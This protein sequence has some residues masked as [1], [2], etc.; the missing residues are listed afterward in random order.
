MGGRGSTGHWLRLVRSVRGG[1]LIVLRERAWVA[2]E[3]RRRRVP[4]S[5]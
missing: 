3:E 1:Q 5:Q 2:Q 4:E